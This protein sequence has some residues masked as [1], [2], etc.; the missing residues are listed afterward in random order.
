LA[1]MLLVKN[2][3][4]ESAAVSSSSKGGTTVSIG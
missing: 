1:V 4:H 2:L 3:S